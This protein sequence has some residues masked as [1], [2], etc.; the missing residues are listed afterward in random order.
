MM[1]YSKLSDAQTKDTGG[2]INGGYTQWRILQLKINVS[3]MCSQCSEFQGVF[4]SKNSKQ[5]T[6]EN[7]VCYLFIG[8]G[9]HMVSAYFMIH[10]KYK[11]ESNESD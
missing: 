10:G 5:S 7:K 11:P 9:K 6:K 1:K 3:S 8:V 2:V 4:I